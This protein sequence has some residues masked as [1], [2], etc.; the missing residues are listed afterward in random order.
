MKTKWW[1]AFIMVIA[2][3]ACNISVPEKFTESKYPVQISPDY[4]DLILPFNIAPLN[5]SI[6]EGAHEY[7]TSIHAG[8][9][10]PLVYKGKNVMI[11]VKD[12]HRLLNENRGGL[13]FFDIYLKKYGKWYKQKSI[14]NKIAGEAIDEYLSYRL[15]APSYETYN[16]LSIMQQNLTDFDQR[17]IYSN[18]RLNNKRKMQCINCHSYQNYKTDNMQFHVRAD[19]GGTV[20]VSDGK[21]RKITMKT[22]NLISNGVYP[23]WHPTEKLIAYSLNKTGQVFHKKNLEKVE[24]QDAASDLILYDVDKNEMSVIL[25]DTN[26]METF[27]AW[28]PDGKMLYYVS[29]GYPASD[30]KDRNEALKIEYRN[31]RYSV[32]RLSFDVKTRAFGKPEMVF[33]AAAIGKSAAFPRVSPDGRY[34][35]FTLGDYGNFH[36]WHKS[37]DLHL[38]DLATG[39]ERALD[40]VNSKD[41]ESYHSWSSNGRWIVFSTRRDDGSY[42][43]PYIA[44][45][46]KDGKAGK[47]FI[48][49]QKNPS[50]YFNF[51]KSFNIPE[52]MVEPV[53]VSASEFARAI[54]KDAV[55]AG[56]K[57]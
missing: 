26:A 56:L 51:M 53:R 55:Q 18:Q 39:K 52:F 35:L 23:A 50:F 57:K 36:I 29:A 8:N 34:L 37:A 46:G 3:T 6:N 25:N 47:P 20:I 14:T 45:F 7:I 30:I 17:V 11:D 12:W 1:P 42:T 43:R 49:P 41:V 15:I 13:L 16:E 5:F 21:P 33:D 44:Y 40:E 24:V 38:M 9:S 27:P 4:S 48:L 32:M 10:R 54:K 31:V 28:S 2:L 19:Y 22:G